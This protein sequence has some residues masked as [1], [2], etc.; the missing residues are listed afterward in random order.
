[1][2]NWYGAALTE[3]ARH[4]SRGN[5]KRTLAAIYGGVLVG[6]ALAITLAQILLERGI[7]NTGGLSGLGMRSVLQTIGT[8][9]HG[10]NTVLTPF[11]NLGFLFAALLW[12]RGSAVKPQDLLTGF[13]RFGPYLRLLILRAITAIAGGAFCVYLSSALYMLTPWSAT[14]MDFAQS[15]NMDMEAAGTMVAQM[16]AAQID[17]MLISMIPMLAIWFVLCLAVVVPMLYRF[18]M[19]E[20]VILDDRRMGGL[21]AM[22]LSARMLRKRRWKLFLLDLRFWWYYGLQVL[23]LS[24]SFADLWL[25]VLGVVLPGGLGTTMGLYLVYLAGLVLIHTFLSPRVQTAYALAYEKLRQMDPVMPKPHPVPQNL[26]WD[27]E[28]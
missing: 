15:V 6:A 16:D 21:A 25:P 22:L 26:P 14:V 3:D 23:C 17:A 10:A 8:V 7:G 9:L 28:Q 13:R 19:A 20:F 11:W 12:A 4:L 5:E 1:M 24:I 27:D 2:E 18:R